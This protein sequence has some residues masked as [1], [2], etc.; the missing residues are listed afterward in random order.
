MRIEAPRMGVMI[1]MITI[2]IIVGREEV[3]GGRVGRT[4]WYVGG[5]RLIEIQP[6]QTL[7]ALVVVCCGGVL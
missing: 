2:G 3:M 7:A 6:P 4:V 5:A 1:K